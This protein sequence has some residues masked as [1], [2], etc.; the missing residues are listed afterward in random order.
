M[1]Q[2]RYAIRST[3]IAD[4]GT[5]WNTG[6]GW[7]AGIPDLDKLLTGPEVDA[8][9]KRHPN[10]QVVDVIVHRAAVAVWMKAFRA[11]AVPNSTHEQR[12]AARAA[13]DAAVKA[14][15]YTLTLAA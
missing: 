5:V 3:A 12:Q 8:L 9:A 7:S 11:A 4:C 14:A 6:R 13:G 10:V 1:T 2:A 15:G